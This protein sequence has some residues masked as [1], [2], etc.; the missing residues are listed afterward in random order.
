MRWL[1]LW[2]HG[3]STMTSLRRLS[4][5]NGGLYPRRE[6]LDVCSMPSFSRD[7]TKSSLYFLIFPSFAQPPKEMAATFLGGASTN[8]MA[9]SLGLGSESF[10]NFGHHEHHGDRIFQRHG[11]REVMETFCPAHCLRRCS[12]PVW[13]PC[14]K[15]L[16]GAV[17]KGHGGERADSY[18]RISKFSWSR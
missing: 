8:S 18:I 11:H 2:I 6:N 13:N 9:C 12:P 16:V 17:I 10:F 14:P 15:P 7:R 5:S 1:R 3:S 4:S